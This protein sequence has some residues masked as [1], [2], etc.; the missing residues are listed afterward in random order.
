MTGQN[1]FV[2]PAS[3]YTVGTDYPPIRIFNGR[4]D[5]ELCRI[6]PTTANVIPKAVMSMLAANGTVYLTTW[7]SGTTSADWAGRV[8]QL[9]T[10]T[11]VLTV[12]GTVFA[13]GEMPYALAWHMGRLWCGTNNGIGTVGKVYYFR[14]GIDTAWT[15]DYTTSTSSAGG[16]DSLVSYK[17]KLYV[18]TDNAAASRGKVLVRDT[19]GA[20]TTSLTGTGGTAR[21]NN[22][23]LQL[24]VFGT[25]LYAAYWNNDSPSISKIEK[26]DGSSWTTAYT[27]AGDT[28][29]PFIQL[30][31]D[32][33]FL[34]AFGGG[35]LL[36]A[37][38]LSTSNGT[39]WT[40]LTDELPET[41]ETLLPMF[42]VV[43]L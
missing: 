18:G 13:A 35:N 7:D 22:G 3:G 42:G 11:G 34:Y 25:N 6:P 29:K 1:S 40:D 17:G 24:T 15:L 23:Y 26:F 9:D 10:E 37:T 4:S 36:A 16:V 39:S 8:F 31:V 32:N 30:V 43:V 2:Y 28:I 38:I 33:D 14:P 41:D 27:G 21:I 19:A 5:K 12:L 20:Y